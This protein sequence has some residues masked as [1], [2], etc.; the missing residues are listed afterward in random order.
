MTTR[1]PRLLR[2]LL[3]AMP[4]VALACSAKSD[5]PAAPI[6]ESA[7]FAVA[8]GVDLSASTRT[9]T[10]LYYRDLIVG[11]GAVAASGNSL[12]VHY[13]GFLTSGTQF[14]YNIAPQTPYPFTLGNGSVIAGWDQ[15][16]PGMRVGGRR[17][18]IIP[19]SLGYGSAGSGSIPG[20]SILVFTVDLV[21]VK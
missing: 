7:T 3:A 4:I 16:V 2:T 14:D 15:G 19:P 20:N 9:S 5:G 11:T 8:L 10:G 13:A 21:T 12:T 6:I 17:Q 18:L 1:I